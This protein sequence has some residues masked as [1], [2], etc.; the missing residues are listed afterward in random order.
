L[1]W[2][3]DVTAEAIPVYG[4]L[5][6]IEFDGILRE[7]DRLIEGEYPVR[8]S[9]HLKSTL[10]KRL[11]EKNPTT[12]MNA[13][14][15]WYS[16]RLNEPELLA[17]IDLNESPDG[18]YVFTRPKLL[19]NVLNALWAPRD[20]KCWAEALDQSDAWVLGPDAVEA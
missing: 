14:S 12:V 18:P 8:T 13:L 10:L 6:C 7:L 5:E 4:A 9:D 15:D 1:P 19:R 11:A 3:R 17:E 2:A 20:T 16:R